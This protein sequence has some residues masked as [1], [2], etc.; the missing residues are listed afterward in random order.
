MFLLHDWGPFS[1]FSFF[2]ASQK[3]PVMAL[4]PITAKKTWMKCLCLEERGGG[5]AA[6]IGYKWLGGI[7]TAFWNKERMV[8]VT[9]QVI[10][11]KNKIIALVDF[12]VK[13]ESDI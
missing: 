8:E 4:G 10:W 12:S 13:E 1:D 6:L 5:K 2:K 7:Q 9:V 11:V 3:P